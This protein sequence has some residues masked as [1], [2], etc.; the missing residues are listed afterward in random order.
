M[1]IP[2]R[3]ASMSLAIILRADKDVREVRRGRRPKVRNS[4]VTGAKC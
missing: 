2:G 1:E 4:S 3:S